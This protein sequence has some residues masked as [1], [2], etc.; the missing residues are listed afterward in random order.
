MP[1]PRFLQSRLWSQSTKTLDRKRNK[2]YIIRQLLQ[3]GTMDDLRW[4]FRHYSIPTIKAKFSKMKQTELHPSA[5][6]FIAL[7]LKHPYAKKR[8]R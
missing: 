4:L 7:M 8:T 3:Y 2:T 5:R 1:V 6:N